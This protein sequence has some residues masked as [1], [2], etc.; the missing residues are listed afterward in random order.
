VAAVATAGVLVLMFDGLAN[1]WPPYWE[2]LPGAYQA[3]GFERSAGPEDVA[4]AAWA[5]TELG[6]GNRFAADLGNAPVI[7]GYGDQDPVYN[8]AYVYLSAPYDPVAVVRVED[9]GIA[10][11][12]VDERLSR[13]LPASG[14]YFPGQDPG[15]GRYT[16]PLPRAGLAKFDRIP[17]VAR[18]YDSGS[19]VIYGL[20]GS[21]YYVP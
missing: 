10:Y 3:G 19:I 1:G 12:L 21:A 17:G 4:A 14:A 8:D 13:L 2:R 5:L 7:G 18:V 11:V 6:P 15:A 20:K 16:R 9:D